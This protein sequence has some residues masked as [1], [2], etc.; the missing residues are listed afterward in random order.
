MTRVLAA[1]VV[2]SWS[3]AAAAY[4]GELQGD[5]ELGYAH[6]AGGDPSGPG[7]SGAVGVR[8][9]LTDAWNLWGAGSYALHPRAGDD[10]TTV[11]VGGLGGGI[12]WVFDVLR[13]VPWA[14]A[15]VEGL[16]FAGST[17]ELGAAL[18][19]SAGAD[20][21]LRRG[22]SIGL[23][24]RARVVLSRLDEVPLMIVG[25]LRLSITLAD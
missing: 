19:V 14:G 15:G 1:F 20:Y 2:L 12:E 3:S 23:V 7:A 8:Y 25:A 24:G 5:V 10:G 13:V 22:L 17:T 16:V 21:L 4:E 9:A 6:L 11:H 18:Q